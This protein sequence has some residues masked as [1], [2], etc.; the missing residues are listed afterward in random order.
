MKTKIWYLRKSI[1]HWSIIKRMIEKSIVSEYHITHS[2]L[3]YHSYR[4]MFRLRLASSIDLAGGDYCF[5]CKGS[6]RDIEGDITYCVIKNF[7]CWGTIDKCFNG[8]YEKWLQ[9]S[10]ENR[11][12]HT[13]Q[14]LRIMKAEYKKMKEEV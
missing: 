4:K 11:L 8:V 14:M 12:K 3:K 13:N 10:G 5:L 9:S 7:N 2:G 1:I 6:E